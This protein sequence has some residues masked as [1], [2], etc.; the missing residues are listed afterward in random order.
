MPSAPLVLGHALP[1][2]LESVVAPVAAYYLVLLVAGFR[3]ALVGALIWSLS[4]IVRRLLRHERISTL[5]LVGTALLLIRTTI[6]FITGSEFLYFIQPTASTFLASLVLVC[7]ALLGRPFTQRFTHD[8]C[9]LG[10]ELLARSTVH[11]FFVRISFLWAVAMFLNGAVV[12]WLLLT[13]PAN[14]FPIERTGISLSLTAAAIG[15]SIWWFVRTM[16]R[17]GVTIRF[18]ADTRMAPA[19]PS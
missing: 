5:I 7:S 19:S 2:V 4:V 15:L 14:A 17:D 8:F 6:S 10:P 12:L 11:R 13:A 3:G 9:P 16:R 1:I 18:G